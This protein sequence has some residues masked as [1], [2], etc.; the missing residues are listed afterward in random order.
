MS[1]VNG[2]RQVTGGDLRSWVWTLTHDSPFSSV[3]GRERDTWPLSLGFLICK[4]RPLVPYEF[5]ASLHIR[6]QTPPD[7][8]KSDWSLKAHGNNKC[9]HMANYSGHTEPK[10]VRQRDAK[11]EDVV[12]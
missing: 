6:F 10:P 7:D 3:R 11:R 12:S 2:A 4:M 8:Q 9:K 5:Q 1:E